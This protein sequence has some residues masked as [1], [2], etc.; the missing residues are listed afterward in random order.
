MGAKATNTRKD[1]KVLRCAVLATNRQGDMRG[2]EGAAKP[3]HRR[4]DT[5]N[6]RLDDQLSGP[7]ARVEQ[8]DGKKAPPPLKT[9]A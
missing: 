1:C 6:R 5:G 3:L 4:R 2:Y 9:T 8:I 7:H